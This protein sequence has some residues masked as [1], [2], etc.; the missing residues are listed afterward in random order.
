MLVFARFCS[1][2]SFLV[3]V[4][5]RLSRGFASADRSRDPTSRVSPPTKW[6]YPSP[7]E[8]GCVYWP[9]RLSST[10]P[11]SRC[12]WR[13]P[14]AA[15]CPLTVTLQC[16]VSRCSP[17]PPLR[18]AVFV[19]AAT[20][21]V[22]PVWTSERDVCVCAFMCALVREATGLEPVSVRLNKALLLAGAQR[23][24]EHPRLSCANV[25]FALL[26]ALRSAA[27]A[28]QSR[29]FQR[30]FVIQT[31]LKIRMVYHLKPH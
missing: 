27:A 28:A 10:G 24:G 23:S 2:L 18:D 14:A 20:S 19:C 13:C 8:E 29:H 31:A 11:A 17:P 5:A 21:G 25:S 3:S 7:C 12:W 4:A 26:P 15:C 30:P 6:S 1:F 22:L 16:S 9:S